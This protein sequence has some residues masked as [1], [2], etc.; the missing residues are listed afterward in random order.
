[1]NL[2]ELYIVPHLSGGT[3]MTLDKILRFRSSALRISWIQSIL[4]PKGNKRLD[5]Q[6]FFMPHTYKSLRLRAGAFL[7]SQKRSSYC[8]ERYGHSLKMLLVEALAC[9][10]GRAP[11]M[12]KQ[13]RTDNCPA[14]GLYSI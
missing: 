13:Q 5:L 12:H 3:G 1:V 2:S 7:P 8:E 9:P 4:H 14:I 10:V 11:D 6:Q